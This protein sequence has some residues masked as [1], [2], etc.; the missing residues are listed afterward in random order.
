M[1]MGNK[2]KQLRVKDVMSKD[3]VAVYPDDSLH[4]A[5]ELIVENRVSALPVTNGNGQCVG[6]LSTSDLIDLTHELDDELQNLGRASVGKREWLIEQLAGSLGS[7]YVS[8]QMTQDV[9]TISPEASLP[10]AA[11]MML[12]NRVHRL[13]VTGK[14]NKLLGIV[15][16]I[17]IMEVVANGAE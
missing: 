16:T 4:E 7:E 11:A 8:E 14:D 1:A 6:L 3:I 17:D 13:P 2:L 5:L 12:R 10:E 9:A 15:S